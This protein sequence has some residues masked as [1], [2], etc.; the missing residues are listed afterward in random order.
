MYPSWFGFPVISVACFS[1]LHV[2]GMVGDPKH[3]LFVAVLHLCY[4]LYFLIVPLSIYYVLIPD[5]QSSLAHVSL[6][7]CARHGW[8]SESWPIGVC[9]LH[10]YAYINN[11]W[12]CFISILYPSWFRIPSHL[13]RMFL[14]LA[15]VRHGWG[16]DAWP[17]LLAVF[18]FVM[19]YVLWLCFLYLYCTRRNDSD[20]QSSLV[21]VSLCS[22]VSGMVGVR[23]ITH[24]WRLFYIYINLNVLLYLYYC[25]RPNILL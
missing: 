4:A 24:N 8:G 19:L 21:H 15:C 6:F 1:L 16:S 10:F 3:D 23:I 7:A 20:F 9:F 22:H 17:T 5:S 18:T 2:S 13:C 12:M 25:I 14:L 11:I